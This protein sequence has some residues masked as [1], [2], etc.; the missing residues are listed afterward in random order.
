MKVGKS[1]FAYPLVISIARGDNF[2]DRDTKRGGVLILAVEEHPR[3]VENRLKKLGMREEDPIFVHEGF[4]PNNKKALGAVRAFI[5]EK[6][7]TLVL[8]DSLSVF[9]NVKDENDNA[10]I[11]REVKPLLALARDTE[12][13]V[14]LIHHDSTSGGPGGR[15][16]RGGS[17]L[18]GLVDQAIMLE[19][20]PGE[21]N[22]KRLLKTLGRYA[23]S[24]SELVIEL[25]G[26]KFRVVGTREEVSRRAEMDKVREVLTVKPM[27]IED[28]AKE[29]EIT[30]KAARRACK[31]LWD[32]GQGEI[33]QE[34]EG[35]R[36][37]PLTYRLPDPPDSF[38]SHPPSIGKETNSEQS[39]DDQENW[40]DVSIGPS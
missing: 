29:A 10:A 33:I 23:E 1:T 8:V 14:G 22:N 21:M 4:L 3:D 9:W 6:E 13:A 2:L 15:N 32:K 16:I 24:P 36:G 31:A 25:V 5:L 39:E 20:L 19:H 30:Q 34:G 37:D 17:A 40:E 7:I 26:N 28:I 38:L 27:D 11:V 18:F 12:A 35:K